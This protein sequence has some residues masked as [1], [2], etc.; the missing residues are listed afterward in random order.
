M[1]RLLAS[2]TELIRIL[3]CLLLFIGLAGQ[4][5]SPPREAQR[6]QQLFEAQPSEALRLHIE[7]LEIYAQKDPARAHHHAEKAQVLLLNNP[8]DP[9]LKIR[10]FLAW[11]KAHRHMGNYEEALADLNSARPEAE[12]LEDSRMLAKILLENALVFRKMARFEEALALCRQAAT[13]YQEQGD[14]AGEADTLRVIGQIHRSAGRYE[15]A[16]TAFREGLQLAETAGDPRVTAALYSYLAIIHYFQGAYPEA[17]NHAESALAACQQHPGCRD[18][19]DYLNTIALTYARLGDWDTALEY[20]SATLEAHRQNNHAMGTAL[21]L[22]NISSI[23]YK[24]DR[25]DEA[26]TYL[27]EMVAINTRINNRRGLSIGYRNLAAL[28]V[29]RGNVSEAK[30]YLEKSVALNETEQDQRQSIIILNLYGR[31]HM[32]TG[33]YEAAKDAFQ[34]E[35]ALNEE[36]HNE[37]ATA[38]AALNL[39]RVSLATDQVSAAVGYLEETERIA[40]RLESKPLLRDVFLEL[41]RCWEK[42]GNYEQALQYHKRYLTIRD[43]LSEDEKIIA[44]NRLDERVELV[45]RQR[46]IDMLEKDNQIQGLR[47]QEEKA[48]SQLYAT[49][50]VV[51]LLVALVGLLVYNRYAQSR[52]L[53]EKEQ[54]NKVL[55]E[56]VQDRT[57]QLQKRM[58]ELETFE[59]LVRTINQEFEFEAV[60][61]ALLKQGARLLP[62]CDNVAFL[63]NGPDLVYRTDQ[64]RQKPIKDIPAKAVRILAASAKTIGDGISIATVKPEFPYLQAWRA[65]ELPEK[66]LVAEIREENRI[67]GFLIFEMNLADLKDPDLERLELFREH[68]ILAFTKAAMIRELAETQEDFTEAAHLAGMAEVAG[69]VLHNLGN[70]LTSVRTSLHVMESELNNRRPRA[71]LE[72]IHDIFVEHRQALEALSHQANFEKLPGALRSISQS[73]NKQVENLETENRRLGECVAKIQAILAEQRRVA[74]ARYEKHTDLKQLIEKLVARERHRTFEKPIEIRCDLVQLPPVTLDRFKLH[75]ILSCLLENAFQAIEAASNVKTGLVTITALDGTEN[76]VIIEI[77]DNGE[78]FAQQEHHKLFE[79]GYT[80]RPGRPGSGLHYAANALALANGEIHILSEGPDQGARVRIHLPMGND[81][82]A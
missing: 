3:G 25:L 52:L 44:R 69:E 19:A 64:G 10:L 39:A 50:L 46:K 24:M 79:N 28:H 23:H 78:G 7:L 14:T 58:D 56:R 8:P 38:E 13:R 17:L 48:A 70:T 51:A 76:E 67:F 30:D 4:A 36:R 11:S 20:Y 81:L 71:L 45:R 62:R 82:A 41:S 49:W 33:D 1:N 2:H 54:H 22:N 47:L 21:T 35:K 16:K 55:E 26:E 59:D 80:T 40:R 57:A 6:E 27:E 60:I 74:H 65:Q 18:K 63:Q 77:T 29:E 42:R 53:H 61:D 31:L 5:Q 12:N 15:D 9:P 32:L 72:K 66:M 34:T 73:W 68:A 37:S 75:R 43:N